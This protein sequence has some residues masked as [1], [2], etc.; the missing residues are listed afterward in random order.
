TGGEG[1]EVIEVLN[2]AD[3][4]DV[5]GRLRLATEVEARGAVASAA[6]HAEAW[7]TVPPRERAA[8]LLRAADAMEADRFRLMG[9]LVREAGK[10]YANAVAEVREAVDFLRFYAA[11]VT[12]DFDPATHRPLGVVTC[13]SPWNFPLAIFTGQIAAALAAGNVVIAKPAEQTTLIAAEGVKL[14]WDAGIPREAL[15]LMPGRGKEV[16]PW[17]T[18]DE[19][20]QGVMFT[21]STEVARELQR[22]L[23]KRLGPAGCP[24]PLVAETGGQNAMIVDSSALA[25]QV[26]RDVLIS[27]FDS[28]GQ[29]CSAL[30][31]LCVQEDVAGQITTM[32]KGAMAELRMGPPLCLSNDVGPVIDARARDGINRHIETMAAKGRKVHQLW[33]EGDAATRAAVQRGT[34]VPPTLIEIETLSELKREVFGPVLHLLRYRREDLDQLLAQ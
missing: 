11:Q 30:R 2:P 12:R 27:A 1:G 31:V 13:I 6:A 33:R 34:Y 21:G 18:D 7:A 26:V 4:A 3:H 25:E 15:Q 22:I 19:R 16:G 10:T 29:R 23:A 28:A 17:L 14:L 32:L 8:M 5:V 9:I 20:I 24:V